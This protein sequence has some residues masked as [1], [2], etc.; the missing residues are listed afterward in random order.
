MI[1]GCV[2]RHFLFFQLFMQLGS[3]RLVNGGWPFS[4]YLGASV[5]PCK[6]GRMLGGSWNKKGLV[7]TLDHSHI[8]PRLV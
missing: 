3:Y 2:G 5:A 6:R 7:S 4:A 8:F 1:L